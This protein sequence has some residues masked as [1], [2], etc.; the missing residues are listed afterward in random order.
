[1]IFKIPEGLIIEAVDYTLNSDHMIRDF[2]RFYRDYEL[3]RSVSYFLDLI[4]N[5]KG[6]IGITFGLLT[7]QSL[8]F[9]L[10][11]IKSKRDYTI[12]YY[13]EENLN[14][15]GMELLCDH[16]FLVGLFEHGTEMWPINEHNLPE[17]IKQR[18]DF[19][20][21]LWSQSVEDNIKAHTGKDNLEIEFSEDQ[22]IYAVY[23]YDN[24]E[25]LALTA[26][27][28][29]SSIIAAMENYID[30]DDVCLLMRPFKH[31]GVA[32]LSIYPA[33]FKAK[34]II[35]CSYKQDWMQV[36]QRGTNIHLAYEMIRENWPLP[37]KARMITTGGYPFNSDYIKFVTNQCEVEN[38][39]DCYG[40]KVCVP[41]LA[42]RYLHKDKPYIQPFKWVNKFLQP[43]NDQGT[44]TIVS[45]NLE[46]KT[47]DKIEL[48]GDLFYF[49][50][51]Q[52]KTIRMNHQVWNADEFL[53][54]F[55]DKTNI[56]DVK[57]HFEE[58]DNVPMPFL[59]I[60][61][62]HKDS[63]SAFITKNAVE[64]KLIIND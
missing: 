17:E 7:Y 10:A 2:K 56:K 42:I 16:V 50:G 45:P 61:A 3:A 12:F 52:L 60:T 18:P 1:M 43:R 49:Y 5:T 37:K 19:Y 20:T 46:V 34:R 8:A 44:L 22:K 14:Y 62:K 21:R 25:V 30:D 64:I 28:E 41:P 9:M 33:L 47:F 24:Q 13:Q 40:T 15:K 26:K 53:K 38:I 29:E 36:Y 4:S 58:K 48:H 6:K 39:I 63:V 59:T 31:I 51:S 57:L 32:T 54:F 11:L 23:D 27:I 55:E 35:V